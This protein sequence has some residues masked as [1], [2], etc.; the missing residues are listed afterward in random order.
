VATK[1]TVYNEAL[2]ALKSRR[3]ANLTENRS[4]RRDLD[5]V[6]DASLD[7][8]LE[9]ALWNFATAPEEWTP[10][11]TLES[12]F[13][14]TYVYEKPDDYMRLVDI[15]ANERFRPTL[16]DFAEEGDCFL[17]DVSPMW[18]RYVSTDPS[19]GRD[20]GKWKPA[21]ARALALELAWRAG[22]HIC[23]LS[24]QDKS[25]LWKEK[26]TALSQAKASDAVNQPMA[27]LPAGRLVSA[28]AGR[29]GAYNNMRRTP[30]A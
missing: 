12:Q 25:D 19:K 20:P 10:S 2:L 27:M 24:A 29:R 11:D 4:E 30:Y 14:Y 26:K 5:A 16:S 3:L 23:S 1:L 28:R 22:P 9:R 17:S 18:V 7:W 13:G 8:M 15:S 21:F 6:W